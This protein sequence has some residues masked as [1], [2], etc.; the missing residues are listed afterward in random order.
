MSKSSSVKRTRNA[1]HVGKRTIPLKGAGE[2][3]G[4]IYVLKGQVLTT[5]LMTP[6]GTKKH[7]KIQVTRKQQHR[8]NRLLE[9]LIQ[10][11][12]SATTTNINPDVDT[13]IRHV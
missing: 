3:Q 11:T 13:T 5:K 6:P 8:A 9:K 12:N 2:E 4:H 1:Q 7:P 10:K